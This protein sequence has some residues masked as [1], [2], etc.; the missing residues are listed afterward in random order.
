MNNHVPE[1][2]DYRSMLVERGMELWRNNER[3]YRTVLLEYEELL[4]RL[5]KLWKSGRFPKRFKLSKQDIKDFP[6]VPFFEISDPAVARSI[7]ESMETPYLQQL[8]AGIEMAVSYPPYTTVTSHVYNLKRYIY[9][10]EHGSHNKYGCAM[11]PNACGRGRSSGTW[12]FD[13]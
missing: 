13:E 12:R 2:K 3:K 7:L 1:Q 8:V 4:P 10:L 5:K 9:R 11:N 6:V